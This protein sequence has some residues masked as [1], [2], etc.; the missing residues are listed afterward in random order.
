MIIIVIW[1]IQ[2]PAIKMEQEVLIQIGFIIFLKHLILITFQLV[3]TKMTSNYL[4]NNIK[5]KKSMKK[6][7]FY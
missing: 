5:Y 3:V 4:I 6:I 1:D 2:T 7:L